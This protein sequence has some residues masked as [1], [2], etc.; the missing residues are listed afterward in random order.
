MLKYGIQGPDA[1]FAFGF[2]L[3]LSG[4]RICLSPEYIILFLPLFVIGFLGGSLMIIESNSKFRE[5][6]RDFSLKRRD[7]KN[8]QKV[9]D[10]GTGRDLFA[11]E[12]AHKGCSAYGIDI[13]SNQ[14]LLGNSLGKVKK[15]M[16]RDGIEVDF[17]YGD[18]RE[19]PFVD[20]F[21]DSVVCSYLVHNIHK[22]SEMRMAI[23]ELGRVTKDGSK[24]LL[25]DINPFLGPGWTKSV[26][27]NELEKENFKDVEFNNFLL[28][29]V[30]FTY[31]SKKEKKSEGFIGKSSCD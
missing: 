5:R 14:D 27:K 10:V 29:S 31:V 22:P 6:L 26:W 1:V 9:L 21:F 7:P 25:A 18:I 4:T 15:N 19:I 3:I 17:R 11:I 23:K 2:L 16:K 12:L 24:V 8:N 20:D 13:W 30:I 28:T